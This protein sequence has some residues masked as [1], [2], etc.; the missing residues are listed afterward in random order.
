MAHVAKLD[1]LVRP[2]VAGESIQEGRLVR[3]VASGLRNDLPTAL[4]ATSG[5]TMNVYVAFVPPDNFARP[6]PDF[7]YTAPWY[8]TL[9]ETGTWGNNEQTATFRYEGLSVYE[10][11]TAVSGMYLQ[12]RRGGIYHV[13]SGCVVVSANLKVVGNLAKVSDDGTGR[14][15]YTS[16][17][18]GA[19]AKVVDYNPENEN[20]TFEFLT[21]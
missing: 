4:L 8:N 6:T 3:L 16:S 9:Q 15:E 7:M 19:V 17:E 11:P 2:S 5:T 1:G 14:F 20:Y 12:A 10:N 21:K 18:T 13:P